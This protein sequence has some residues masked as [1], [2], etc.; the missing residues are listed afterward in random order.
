VRIEI[1]WNRFLLWQVDQK[2]VS[3]KPWVFMTSKDLE[4]MVTKLLPRIHH[5]EIQTEKCER[6]NRVSKKFGWTPKSRCPSNRASI[7]FHAWKYTRLQCVYYCL[8]CIQRISKLCSRSMEDL[9]VMIFV[10]LPKAAGWIS[11]WLWWY[12]RWFRN[13][14][15]INPKQ[16]SFRIAEMAYHFSGYEGWYILDNFNT[17]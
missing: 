14:T 5:S 3:F 12:C 8:M 1:W 4:R 9:P 13:P 7:P 11:H 16:L 15:E 6:K 10:E 2:S 17:I